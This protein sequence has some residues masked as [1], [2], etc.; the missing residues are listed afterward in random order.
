[1]AR[2]Q[3]DPRTPADRPGRWAPW[4][5][6]L[7]VLLGANYLRSWLMPVGTVP[8]VAVVAI[9]LAQAAVLFVVVTALWR[10]ARRPRR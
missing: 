4:W 8:E 6:Y 10:V 5:I 1:M 2:P 3:P 9:G 7:V